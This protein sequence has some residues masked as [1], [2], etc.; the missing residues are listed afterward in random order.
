[1]EDRDK[2]RKYRVGNKKCTV[3]DDKSSYDYEQEINDNVI[4]IDTDIVRRIVLI[5][6][7]IID[8]LQ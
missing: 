8:I 4:I 5:I 6:N 7:I 3:D 1:M 2:I